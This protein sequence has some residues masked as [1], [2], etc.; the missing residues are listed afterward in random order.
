MKFIIKYPY[1]KSEREARE[2]KYKRCYETL[3]GYLLVFTITVI[4]FL[5]RMNF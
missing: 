4:T 3:L 2:K 1:R 5:K